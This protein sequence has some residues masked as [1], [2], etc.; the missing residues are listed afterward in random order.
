MRGKKV[1]LSIKIATLVMI[2]SLLGIAALAYISYTQAKEI[3]MEHSAQILAKNTDQY[4]V[5]IK[6]NIER[7][8]YNITIFTYN[9]SVK[10]F[11]RAYL[12]KYKYDELTNKTFGQY[13]KDITTIITLMM[14]QNPSYFQMRII[15]AQKGNEIIKLIKEKGKI[16]QIEN[17][18]L[19]NKWKMEYVQDTLKLTKSDL[20]ISKI[21]LNREFNAIEFPIKP[22]IRI[23]KIIYANGKKAGI[24][25]IN[26]NVESLFGFE[27]L[28]SLKDTKTYI[29]NAEGYYIFNYSDPQ[30][31]FGFEFGKDFRIFNDFPIM[32]DFYDSNRKSFS[33]IDRE[34]DQI[35]E[36][37]KLYV[38]PERYIVIMKISTASAFKNKSED[39]TQNL[40]AVVFLITLLITLITTFLVNRLTVPIKRLTLLANKISKSRGK[41]H[42]DI[43]VKTDDEIGELAKAFEVMIKTLDESKKELEDFA[44]RLEEEVE[45]KTEE[46]Q[47]I[48]KNLQ[49]MVQEKVNEIREKDRA[50]IQQSKMAAMGEM[51]GAIAHQWRQ[52]LNSLAIN[53]QLLEDLAEEGELDL[54][55]IREFVDKNM[56]TIGFMSQT[57]DDF[58]NFFRKDREEVDF[59]VKEAIEKTISLQRTQLENHNIAVE[60]ELEDIVIKGFKNEFMQM[61]LNL[62]SNAKDAIEERRIKEGNYKGIIKIEA[63][64]IEDGVR[65]DISDNGIGIKS[66]LKE[67]V[68]EPYFTTK[69]EGR[70]TGMGLYM[71]KEIVERMGGDI[72]FS[73]GPEGTTFTLIIRRSDEK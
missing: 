29:A 30:K 16:V 51:I 41:E 31:V 54:E 71:V 47:K 59:N 58:R 44:T 15:D 34:N 67:R 35:I 72:K 13:K 21:N 37:R 63:K 17:E 69:E 18:N 68:F 55:K 12:D 10:G 23:A 19:Q 14:K 42:I 57:I 9:P 66:D 39:Y 52:P 65:I 48:N 53:I 49:K 40:I 38:T 62:I 36:A 64:K 20:Y 4:A 73:T 46:L 50:L 3:F 27:R 45:K 6:D 26:A 32:K 2:V 5:Y 8:K 24:A 11:M 70:G 1:S 28:K 60:T 61:I 43:D 22:T 33:Y 7:L 56:Q 25:V